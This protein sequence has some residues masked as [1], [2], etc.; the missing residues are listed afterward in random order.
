MKLRH[1]EFFEAVIRRG[2]F[3]AAALELGVSQPALS[4]GVA[5]LE[6]HVGADL[7]DRSRHGVR[8][9]AAGRGFRQPALEALASLREAREAV[10]RVGRLDG[11]S[12]EIA[13]PASLGVDPVAG[14]VG[15]FHRR[16]PDISVR[17][18]DLPDRRVS[19][20]DVFDL[21]VDLAITYADFADPEMLTI[22]LNPVTLAA[23][24]SGRHDPGITLDEL[25]LH[26]LV[27][28]SA[29]DGPRLLLASQIEP[30]TFSDAIVVEA[31]YTQAILP[32]VL[33]GA[34]AAVVPARQ[35]E[36][37]AAT[38]GVTVCDLLP[39][40]ELPVVIAVPVRAMSAAAHQ[41][42]AVARDDEDDSR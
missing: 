38:P 1:L 40:A 16:F 42:I 11:G 5:T 17:I 8:L 4:Q 15:R 33:S 13:C 29:T 41:F 18:K 2:S 35:A 36:A 31:A 21:G 22:R 25:L 27:T 10:H 39:S 14:L 7:F 26:G 24:L 9:T 37:V 20:R 3:S 34:G 23:V 32:L 28:T 12:L 30:S 19:E 6:G